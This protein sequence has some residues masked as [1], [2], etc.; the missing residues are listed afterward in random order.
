[1]KATIIKQ[2]IEDTPTQKFCVETN[3]HKKLVG[4]ISF[5]DDNTIRIVKSQDIFTFIDVENVIAIS[6][7]NQ[8]PEA[9]T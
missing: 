9:S 8:K 4:Q 7:S 3:E 5:V 2:I 1:M 6:S